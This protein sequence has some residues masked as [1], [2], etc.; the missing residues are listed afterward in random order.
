MTR[1]LN[2][3]ASRQRREAK[4]SLQL[5]S[6]HHLPCKNQLIYPLW[7]PIPRFLTRPP[8][9]LLQ[10]CPSPSTRF[11]FSLL[12]FQDVNQIQ[13]TWD[14]YDEREQLSGDT[15]SCLFNMHKPKGWPEGRIPGL[16]EMEDG[17]LLNGSGH[18]AQVDCL[19]LLKSHSYRDH[20]EESMAW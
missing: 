2:T 7:P 14:K 3:D 16:V 20:P 15:E 12:T 1:F 17:K 13:T 8:Q 19:V 10:P 9:A 11:C 18:L 5:C 6:D 4:L